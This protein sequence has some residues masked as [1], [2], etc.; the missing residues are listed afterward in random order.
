MKCQKGFILPLLLI[1]IAILF[2]S[3][4]VYV[5]TQ[6]YQNTEPVTNNVTLSQATS[7]AQNIN[8][9]TADW[10]TYISKERGFEVKYPP[11]WIPGEFSMNDTTRNPDGTNSFSIGFTGK[12]YN[13]RIV[14]GSSPSKTRQGSIEK[15]IADLNTRAGRL[16][17]AP[18]DAILVGNGVAFYSLESVPG[19]ILPTVLLVGKN[20]ILHMQITAVYWPDSYDKDISSQQGE[21]LFKKILSTFKFNP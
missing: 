3:G 9:K 17:A 21:I 1:V 11:D 20:E 2:V 16:V 10:K 19:D 6:K 14:D 4:G 15:N 8:S 12:D 7:T 18:E 13:L 5:Y